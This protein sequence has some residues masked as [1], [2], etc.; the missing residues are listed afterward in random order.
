MELR[1]ATVC[2]CL[3]NLI[4]ACGSAVD[5]PGAVRYLGSMKTT[6]D[7]PALCPA[8]VV[9][10]NLVGPAH[11]V[12]YAPCRRECSRTSSLHSSAQLKRMMAF[13]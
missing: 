12:R 2:V 8:D 10:P 3:N 13:A 5:R 6:T 11:I 9:C 1:I 7:L 4:N